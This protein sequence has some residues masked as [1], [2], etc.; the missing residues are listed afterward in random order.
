MMRISLV[1]IRNEALRHPLEDQV[2]EAE[3]SEE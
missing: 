3:T 2:G 1:F